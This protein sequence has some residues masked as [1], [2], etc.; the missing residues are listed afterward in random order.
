MGVDTSSTNPSLPMTTFFSKRCQ[1]LA[2]HLKKNIGM[3][4]DSQRADTVVGFTLIE[5]LV[6]VAII[7]LLATSVFVVLDPVTRFA[8]A[9][10]SRRWND[11]NSILTASHQYIVDKA[12]TLPTGL[13]SDTPRTEIGTCASCIDLATPLSPFLAEIPQDP[14]HGDA[15]NTGYFVTVDSNNIIT[16]SAE[17]AENEEAIQVSR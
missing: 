17:N 8:D 13:S 12:G 16:I 11:V 6:V 14:Q 1:R 3:H 7:A 10:N 4:V 2:V 15:T 9:R 5:I